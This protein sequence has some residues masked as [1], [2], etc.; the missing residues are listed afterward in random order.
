MYWEPCRR[1]CVEELVILNSP[2][3]LSWGLY[4]RNPHT[5]QAA[6]GELLVQPGPAS[7]G[8]YNGGNIPDCQE[9]LHYLSN[10]LMGTCNTFRNSK[11]GSKGTTRWLW[12]RAVVPQ[13][14]GDA[15]CSWCD[16]NRAVLAGTF[17]PCSFRLCGAAQILGHKTGCRQFPPTHYPQIH[18]VSRSK[19]WS[20]EFIGCKH[21]FCLTVLLLNRLCFLKKTVSN[22][23][24]G[25][26]GR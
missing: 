2:S 26:N 3:L 14:A 20:K 11:F 12:P 16:H 10:F 24:N 17:V 8:C 13:G 1:H 5:E 4:S 19:V 9:T 7:G 6:A 25:Q 22:N 18:D 23:S 21:P 15:P